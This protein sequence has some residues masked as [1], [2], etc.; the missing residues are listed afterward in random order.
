MKKLVIILAM[1]M[2]FSGCSSP[3][4]EEAKGSEIT[5]TMEMTTDLTTPERKSEVYG[6]VNKMIGNEVTVQIV[7]S[8]ELGE[9]E[10]TEEEKEAKRIER[11]SMSPEERQAAKDATMTVTDEKV[12]IIIPVGT[13]IVIGSGSGDGAKTQLELVDIHKGSTVKIWLVEGREGEV[14]MAEYVQ[15]ISN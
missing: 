13:P 9:V 11:Q 15:I 4:I 6:V 2:V 10:L 5:S 7:V 8:T 1:S 12:D 3:S 14:G